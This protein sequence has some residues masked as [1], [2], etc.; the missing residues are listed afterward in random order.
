MNIITRTIAA[1]SVAAVAALGFAATASA[2]G[3]PSSTVKG[4]ADREA[5]EFVATHRITDDR[6]NDG[7]LLV[8]NA[9]G[10]TATT[11][12]GMASGTMTNTY[13]CADGE[14]VT[15]H[16]FHKSHPAADPTT[17]EDTGWGVGEWFYF[18][19]SNR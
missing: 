7:C 18:A 3:L 2:E 8:L 14:V 6:I 4:H 12:V 11:W 13:V 10:E 17:M 19:T 16:I 15:Y 5:G 9:R 1:L